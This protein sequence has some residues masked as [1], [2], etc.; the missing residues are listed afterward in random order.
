MLYV[1]CCMTDADG[2]VH[3]SVRCK[4]CHEARPGPHQPDVVSGQLFTLVRS[5]VR[6]KS[7]YRCTWTAR[8]FEWDLRDLFYRHSG[9][10]K[11]SN[12]SSANE[13]IAPHLIRTLLTANHAIRVES[14][15]VKSGLVED[16]GAVV[17][18]WLATASFIPPVL[19]VFDTAVCPIS[20]TIWRRGVVEGG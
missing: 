5:L 13:R 11:A 12:L 9:I 4:R 17:S 10:G 18:D 6:Y 3:S 2:R 1:G 14:T 8:G 19:H 20:A 16:V 7:K 15:V